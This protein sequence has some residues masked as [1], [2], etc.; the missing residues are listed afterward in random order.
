MQ[1]KKVVNSDV[2]KRTFE[3]MGKGLLLFEIKK[4]ISRNG[5][6]YHFFYGNGKKPP[7]DLS[8][9]PDDN[10]IEYISFLLQDEKIVSRK[11]E[12]TV[13]FFKEENIA[14]SDNNFS[15]DRPHIDFS[16]EFEIAL[17]NDNKIAIVSK[18]V[19]SDLI[20]YRID[21]SN[22]ILFQEGI[23]SGFLM[24]NISTN[25]WE[26]IKESDGL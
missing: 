4:D 22:Y 10:T 26:A 1:I 14:I 3:P 7:L 11:R 16:R 13:F 19:K 23:F 20:G 9:N 18:D 17:L 2:Y 12:D 6:N 5:Q 21:T 25:E 24:E 15:S 8:I